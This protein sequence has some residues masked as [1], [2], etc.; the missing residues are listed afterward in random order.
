M[1]Y[2]EFI[3]EYNGKSIDYDGACGAQ[4]VDL[5]QLYVEKCFTGV[6][7]VIYAN[8]KDYFENF[9]NLPINEI[10]TKIENTADLVPEEG[11][12]AVWGAELGNQYG[13]IAIATGEGNTKEFKSYD[14][15]WG[16]K[17]VHEVTHTYKGF[18]GVLRAKDQSKITGVTKPNIQYKVHIQDIG[19][20]N[21]ENTGETAGTTGENKRIEAIILQGNNG[22]DLKYRVHMAEIG[23]SEWVEN[24][25]IAGTTG[26]CRKIEAIEIKSNKDLE[27]QEHIQEIG[28]IPA[29]KGKN[30]K[31]GTEGKSLRLEAFKIKI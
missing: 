28:W 7:Q 25:Q 3:N 23:W 11:D 4:C 16:N 27:V 22:L 6:H 5:I 21:W 12:I 10:F 31:I 29:S 30:I 26:Q 18:L 14:L 13:H 2:N 19:W 1:N 17:I 24:G 20:T 9:E 8:A 15:N